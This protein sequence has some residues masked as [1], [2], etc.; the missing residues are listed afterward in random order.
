MF[1]FGSVQL[2]CFFWLLFVYFSCAMLCLLINEHEQSA[3][4]VY[5]GHQRRP[6]Y[7]FI[8][9]RSVNMSTNKHRTIRSNG[10]NT[11]F[12]MAATMVSA[13]RAQW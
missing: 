11:K 7:S 12:S 4:S 6:L 2:R 1:H 13:D 8:A 3:S 10:S 9:E 5:Y